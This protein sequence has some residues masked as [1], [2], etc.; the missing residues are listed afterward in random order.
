[1]GLLDLKESTKSYKSEIGTIYFGPMPSA[2]TLSQLKANGITTIVNLMEELP[3][4]REVEEKQFKV[5]HCPVRDFSIPNKKE[6]IKCLQKIY[7]ELQA[8]EVIYVHCFGGRG[9][10][11]M[12]LSGLLMMTDGLS[13]RTA[14]S[15]TES[16]CGGPE[17]QDQKD[18]IINLWT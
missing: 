13:P 15:L 6:F 14:L 8:G 4:V 12:A 1:M 3:S 9:R 17:M 16:L 10:T 5:I 7:N 11:G 18:F 2:N